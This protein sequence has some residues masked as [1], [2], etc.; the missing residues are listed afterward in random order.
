MTAQ[1]GSQ[2]KYSINST[3]RHNFE[4]NANKVLTVRDGTSP[5]YTHDTKGKINVTL[6]VR[7]GTI[8]YSTHDTK[9]NIKINGTWQYY[10]LS[11]PAH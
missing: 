4:A 11:N 10:S 1:F 6:K 8:P 3:W 7:D 5:F 9:G 2:R